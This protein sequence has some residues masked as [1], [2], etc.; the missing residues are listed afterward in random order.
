MSPRTKEQIEL[1][2]ADRKETIL[3]A[4]LKCFANQGFHST[5]VSDIAKEAGISKGLIY[6]YYDSKEALLTGLLDKLTEDG[7]EY[8][9]A[10]QQENPKMAMQKLFELF[11]ENLV[12][13]KELWRLAIALSVQKEVGNFDYMKEN[14]RIKITTLLQVLEGLLDAMGFNNAREESLLIGALLDGIS[15]Q[16]I[17][18]AEHYPLDE[19]VAFL[20]EKYCK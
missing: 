17:V 14:M 4:A 20:N 15:L 11:K 13:K 16:Y 9:R 5:S 2:R 18:A 1:L 6:N 12:N 19:I 10:M 3:M 8:Y 7:E